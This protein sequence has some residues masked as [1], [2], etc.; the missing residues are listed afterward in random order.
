MGQDDTTKIA[1]TVYESFND[2]DFDRGMSVIAD[3]AVWTNV[4][5]SETFR[6]PKGFRTNL[7]QWDRA[8]PEGKIEELRV[9]GGEGFAVA[10]F[11]G[12]GTN[13][14]PLASPAGELPAT[15]R[16]VEVRFCD[17]LEISGGKVTGGRS[18]WDMATMMTQ[19][20]MMPEVPAGATV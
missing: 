19:L 20:G 13:T 4:P 1:R 9:W 6:G 10:E 5:T 2:R 18:Y 11:T 7:E 8:F 17:V 14:G 16:S 15:N 12:R 3:D